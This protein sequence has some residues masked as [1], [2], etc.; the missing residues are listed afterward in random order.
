MDYVKTVFRFLWKA[1]NFSRNLILNLIFFGI[2]FA[3]IFSIEENEQTH[4]M[5][6]Q[7]S[8]LVLNLSGILVEEKR[9]VDP[10]EAAFSDFSDDKEPAEILVDDVVEAIKN[11]ADDSRIKVIVLDLKSLHRAH[12]DKLKSIGVALND[13]KAQ[14]KQVIAYGDYY[15]QAQYYLA[16]YADEVV[17]HP[18]GG[19]SI[20]GFGVY[21]IYFKDAL[22]KLSI[23]Q[24]VF[25]VGTYKSAVEPFI[26]NDMSEAAKEANRL[27]LGELWSHYKNDVSLNRKFD[28]SNFDETLDTFVEKLEQTQGDFAQYALQNKWVDKLATRQ[29]LTEELIG[30]VG[31]DD[32]TKSFN[33][34]AFQDYLDL[35]RLNQFDVPMGDK[36]AVVVAKGSI[37]DGKQRAG[38]IGGD[39]TA[40]LLKKARLDDKVKAVVLR[41]DSGGGS[42][43]AS[44]I[45]RN[46]VLAIKAAG[47]PVVASMGSVAA[48]GGYWI[49]ASANEIWASEN[50]VTGSIGVFGT[51]MTIENSLKKLGIYSD[52]VGTTELQ[53]SSFTRG[54]DPKMVNVI[55]KGVENA[56]DKFITVVSNSRNIPKEKVNEIAQGRVWLAPQA[57]EFGLVDKLGTKDDAIEAAAALANLDHYDVEV[58]EHDL[59]EQEKLIQKIFGVASVKSL[60]GGVYS[61]IADSTALSGLI[62]MAQDTLNTQTKLIKQYNDP[63]GVY[64]RCI[65]CESVQ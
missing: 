50:T 3:V 32:K 25:R 53:G 2:L 7:D 8:A 54:I 40:A 61:S 23:T 19:V 37:M 15:S 20:D 43:F 47:K 5:V 42:M 55:Q 24:H 1:I 45:I 11:A 63:N 36:V 44:E 48:S 34:I 4:A 10:V 58:V 62:G 56:Y 59:T 14:G 57:L 60:M 41:I 30:L 6:A 46:E 22:D 9:Y 21:P 18:Y 65:Y 64:S 26:R 12:L 31:E 33:R 17:L 51:I 35:T 29:E 52:G 13:F 16:S 49:A 28:Q 38:E 27:W 39:S